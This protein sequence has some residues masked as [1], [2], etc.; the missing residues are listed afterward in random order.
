MNKVILTG[1]SFLIGICL[2]AAAQSNICTFTATPLPPD[3]LL[4]VNS[5]GKLS[6]LAALLPYYG[7]L[8]WLAWKY[9]IV[10]KFDTWK[11]FFYTTASVLLLLGLLF[12]WIADV[13][14]VWTF[15]PGRDL[16]MIR[17]PIFGWFSGH[18]IPVCEFLWILGVVPLF[19]YL[20]LWATLAFYDI[21]YVVDGQGR[22]YKKEE[23]W[24]GLHEPTR[25]LTRKKFEKGQQF[26]T[27]LLTR[28]P[29]V[30][31]RAVKKISHAR[32]A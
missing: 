27:P 6:Y 25:I 22:T 31:T 18:R 9:R 30:L 3:N 26:E 28:N 32:K 24:V 4:H 13:L 11:M 5:L 14:Y 29:N 15:P 8:F 19:Y 16:F 21:I 17:V 12:E 23:R 1:L 20:Y 7:L 2:P 10:R